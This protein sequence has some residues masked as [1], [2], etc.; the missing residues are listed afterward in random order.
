MF[1][2]SKDF[3]CF[4]EEEAN[5]IIDCFDLFV[6]SYPNTTDPKNDAHVKIKLKYIDKDEIKSEILYYYP[7]LANHYI[8]KQ[9][10]YLTYLGKN[11][12]KI[13][14][15]KNKEIG[16]EMYCNLLGSLATLIRTRKEIV[17]ALYKNIQKYI[18]IDTSKNKKQKKLLSII[19]SKI[20]E[21]I[22]Q[23]ELYNFQINNLAHHFEESKMFILE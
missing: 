15:I 12:D 4:T 5:K 13:L 1:S 17:D 7:D 14:V 23:E 21:L 18:N 2:N 6:K 22:D 19:E 11:M 3:T 16:K 9:M 10:G 8:F 20:I